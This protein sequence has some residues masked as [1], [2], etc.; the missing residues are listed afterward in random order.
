VSCQFTNSEEAGICQ[1]TGSCFRIQDPHI[2]IRQLVQCTKL[3]E[4]WDIFTT[5]VN[6][7]PLDANGFITIDN[8]HAYLST[9]PE[10]PVG[11]KV[12][13]DAMSYFLSRRNHKIYLDRK[14]KV[15]HANSSR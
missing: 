3:P 6:I 4:L 7:S 1:S 13:W 8:A 14:R 10:L 2:N 12:F 15:N 5:I 9:L 11:L